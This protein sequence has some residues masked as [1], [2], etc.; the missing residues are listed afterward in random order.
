MILSIICHRFLIL[1]ISRVTAS[2]LPIRGILT[3][4]CENGIIVCHLTTCRNNSQL[5]QPH[6][7]S[8]LLRVLATAPPDHPRLS[9]WWLFVAHALGA[10]LT[11]LDWRYDKSAAD[12]YQTPKPQPSK[13]ISIE[14]RSI[15]LDFAKLRDH[16]PSAH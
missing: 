14:A 13:P 4:R 11:R 10:I 9:M 2:G 15:S 5:D 12:S 7:V 16:N 6:E 1:L 8:A 3:D